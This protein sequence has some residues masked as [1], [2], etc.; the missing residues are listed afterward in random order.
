MFNAFS[1]RHLEGQKHNQ[2]G[3]ICRRVVWAT[4]FL[5][6]KQNKQSREKKQVVSILQK[7]FPSFWLFCGGLFKPHFTIDKLLSQCLGTNIQVLILGGNDDLGLILAQGGIVVV[8]ES[9]ICRQKKDEEGNALKVRF[10]LF[11][12]H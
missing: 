3:H 1:N 10:R 4:I 9:T 5:S 12:S 2:M 8:L 11:Y 6:K 7:N